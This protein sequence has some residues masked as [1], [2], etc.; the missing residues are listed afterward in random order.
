MT[1]VT[2]E[3]FADQ[4]RRFNEV[5]S[6]VI[7]SVEE[8]RHETPQERAARLEREEEVARSLSND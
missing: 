6:R 5:R 3:S 2:G 7:R 4:L 1:C 8:L